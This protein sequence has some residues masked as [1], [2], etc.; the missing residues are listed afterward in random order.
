MDQH[1]HF[2]VDLQTSFVC[3]RSL[4]VWHVTVPVW[5]ASMLYPLW[6]CVQSESTWRTK[7]RFDQQLVILWT[8][9]NGF[10]QTPYRKSG[11]WKGVVT[12]S[13][14][15]TADEEDDTSS[16]Q[17]NSKVERKRWLCWADRYGFRSNNQVPIWSS[18]LHGRISKIIIAVATAYSFL[19]NHCSWVANMQRRGCAVDWSKSARGYW[20]G[21]PGS[22]WL[23][24]CSHCSTWWVGAHV[25][26][27]QGR[28]SSGRWSSWCLP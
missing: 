27:R 28:S 6:S 12:K 21:P 19:E 5:S 14:G 25:E 11:P 24:S 16:L 18:R 15:L 17:A 4:A 26:C 3:L 2:L 22:P 20:Y 9:T 13:F 10:I 7:H 23:R 1:N 8:R